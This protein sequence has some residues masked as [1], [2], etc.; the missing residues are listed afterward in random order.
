MKVAKE[1]SFDY[2]DGNRKYG[3][4]GYKYIP[5]RWKKAAQKIIKDYSLKDGSKILDVGCGKGYLLYEIF[6]I[7]PKIEIHGFDISA[8]AVKHVPKKLEK[9]F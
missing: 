7:N 9:I 4:G 8:H 1:Y 6:L 5:G 2:W 3:Y